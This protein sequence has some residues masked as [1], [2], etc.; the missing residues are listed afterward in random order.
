MVVELEDIM[1]EFNH[2][3]YSPEAIK[4]FLKYAYKKWDKYPD[5]VVLAGNGTFDHRDILGYGD[6]LIPPMMVGLPDGLF[7]SDA[8]LAD[9][10]GNDGIPEMAIGRLPVSTRRQFKII[11]NK[12]QAYEE[13]YA[14]DWGK[15]VMVLADNP[16]DGGNF[17]LDSDQIAGHLPMGYTDNRI[18][19]ADFTIDAA[20]QKILE[21]TNKGLLLMNFLG[22]SGVDRFAQEGMIITSDVDLFN[23]EY[24]LPIV[25]A[26]SCI[27]GRFSI[28][29]YDSLS[30]AFILRNN[31]GAIAVWSPSGLSYNDD[32]KMLGEEFFKLFFNS[33]ENNLG[34]IMVEA[35]KNFSY[36]AHTGSILYLFNLLGDPALAIH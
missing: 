7:A 29:G 21:E 14:D 27:V 20:R 23:N 19:L 32:N 15:R 24:R 2:G 6:C 34:K 25:T 22:H 18:Y 16:D 4:T 13:A 36:R 35:M 31:G 9:V 11:L 1:D 33:G 28:P 3:I 5:Y 10:K 30:E 17:S 12:I 8:L 26:M